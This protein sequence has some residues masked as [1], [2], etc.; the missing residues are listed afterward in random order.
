M[1]SSDES[2]SHPHQDTSFYLCFIQ[3]FWSTSLRSYRPTQSRRQ[4]V[5]IHF[6]NHWCFL[7]LGWIVSHHQ[8][9]RLWDGKLSIPTFRS[10]RHSC[11]NSHRSW[12]GFPQLTHPRTYSIGWYRSFLV[13]GILEGGEWYRR[14]CQSRSHTTFDGNTFRYESKQCLVVRTTAYGTTN[15]EHCGKDFNRSNPS[16]A[17]FK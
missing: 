6:G 1:L 5:S 12:H 9:V 13:H 11:G 17:N 14:T 4:R 15:N 2:T 8:C 10:F 16:R 7:S 3:P